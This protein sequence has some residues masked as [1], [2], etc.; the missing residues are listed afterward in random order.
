MNTLVAV[1]VMLN[2]VLALWLWSTLIRPTS[3]E[4]RAGW[5]HT[6]KQGEKAG[7]Q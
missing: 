7:R 3:D 4:I 2:L 6:L 1:L 5:V